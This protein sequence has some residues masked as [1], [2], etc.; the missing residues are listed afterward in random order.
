[1]REFWLRAIFWFWRLGGVLGL[2][3]CRRWWG[4][5][6]HAGFL[7][8]LVLGGLGRV[9]PYS[10]LWLYP[11]LLGFARFPANTMPTTPFDTVPTTPSRLVDCY[12]P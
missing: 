3:G 10:S 8:C 11:G 7:A 6:V 9:S 1:M 12:R 4:I 5:L 2:A